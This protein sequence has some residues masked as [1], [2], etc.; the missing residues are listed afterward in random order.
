MRGPYRD[1]NHIRTLFGDAA[2]EIA[3]LLYSTRGICLV[4]NRLNQRNERL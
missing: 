3:R 2:N 4:R 1:D